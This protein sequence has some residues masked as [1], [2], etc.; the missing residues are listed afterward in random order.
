MKWLEGWVGA[1][2]GIVGLMMTAI[3][4]I[5]SP[6][7]L[8][9]PD[10]YSRYYA[11]TGG[12]LIGAQWIR[13]LTGLPSITETALFACALWGLWLDLNGQRARGR[14]LQL[15]CG[16]LLF[17]M[18]YFSPSP[19]AMVTLMPSIPFAALML[20]AGALACLR[21]ESAPSNAR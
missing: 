18:P 8:N 16:A 20:V 2:G 15:G 11:S 14:I 17:L 21:R 13:L 6:H 4:S 5:T 19:A 9:M 1:L 7:T 12:L 3:F 10:V